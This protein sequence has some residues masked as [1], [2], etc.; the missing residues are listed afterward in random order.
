MVKSET[1]EHKAV[2]AWVRLFLR[3]HVACKVEIK[4]TRGK[5][6]FPFS[7][8]VPH[9]RDD[10]TSFSNGEPFVHKFDD[11]GYRKKPCDIIGIAGGWSFVAIR[12]PK[13]VTIISYCVLEKEM[14]AKSIK[15][16]RAEEISFDIIKIGK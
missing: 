5:D 7:E 3:T 10:L 13:I 14:K 9:Q 8:I 15:Q 2:E 1:K 6:R 12:F 11:S 4:H 16:D